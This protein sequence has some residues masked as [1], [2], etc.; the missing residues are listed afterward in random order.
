MFWNK[1]ITYRVEAI[2]KHSV[3]E[4]IVRYWEATG[5]VANVEEDGQIVFEGV[6]GI[7]FADSG[8]IYIRY[9]D[10]PMYSYNHADFYRFKITEEE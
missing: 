7:T 1:K 4:D 6:G 9:E 5:R 2:P 10:G 3:M 8:V